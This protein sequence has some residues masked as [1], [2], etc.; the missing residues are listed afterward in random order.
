MQIGGVTV[1]GTKSSWLNFEVHRT[2]PPISPPVH[3]E[4]CRDFDSY[5]RGGGQA[6]VPVPDSG[7]EPIQPWNFRYWAD[8]LQNLRARRRPLLFHVLNGSHH[9]FR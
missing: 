1:V 7:S 5:W 2:N 8:L 4:T 6:A 9:D 3:Y